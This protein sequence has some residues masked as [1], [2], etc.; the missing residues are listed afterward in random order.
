M[1]PVSRKK[2]YGALLKD[3]KA[4]ILSAR[5]RTYRGLN[6][7][8][9]KLYWSLGK[10]IVARQKKYGWG[11]S[12]VERLAEDLR[13]ELPNMSGFSGRN[14]WDMRRFFEAYSDEPILRQLVAE[15][16]WG[17]HLLILNKVTARK[18]REYY[19][20][21][22]I[23]MGWS[24][25]V[26]LHQIRN[27][28][29]RRSGRRLNNFSRVLPPSLAEQAE[30]S[31]KSVYSLDFLGIDGPIKERELEARLVARVKRFILEL[32]HGFCFI[33]NQYRLTLGKHEYFLDLLFYNRKLRSLVAVDLKTG[34]FE[35]EH[36]GKMDF[37]L[38]ILN[39]QVRL[40]QE[41]QAVGIVLCADKDDL[42]VEYALKNVRNPVGIGEY[43]TTRTLPRELRGILP[44]AQDMK[45]ALIEDHHP[46]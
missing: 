11:E 13:E 15:I 22:V 9:I 35:P 39:T 4:R 24:R 6:R 44:C 38:N 32:G 28:A 14:L 5:L 1:R 16:P 17:H 30:D 25:N 23:E 42:V 3:V 12:I 43:H 34:A 27:K 36:A 31:I 37:Y 40:P 33:G 45:A 26:L 46:L 10:L 21:S 2:Q 20:R 41:N 18:A 8:L 29:H 7:E 19:I